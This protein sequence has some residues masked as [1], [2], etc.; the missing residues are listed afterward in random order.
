MKKPTRSPIV[1]VLGHVDHG[2][3]T[4]LDAIRATSVAA[5]EAGGITQGIG[6]SVVT[7]KG[8]QIT[9]ID[10]PGHAAFSNMRS[11]GS[12]VADIAILVVDASSGVKPQTIEA[13]QLIKSAKIPFI[14]VI[15]KIDLPSA[16][17]E[18]VKGQLTKEGILF[19]GR[20]G[21][22][23]I[24]P[25]SAKESKGLSELLETISLVAEV[26]EVKGNPDSPLEAVVIESGKDKRG[27]VASIVVRAGKIKIGDKIYAEGISGKVRALFNDKLE[28]VKEIGPGE[29]A[30][31]LGF[32]DV[33]PVGANVTF[34]VIP[35]DFKPQSQ[36]PAEVAQGEI[37]I[38]I[39]AKDLG[40]LEAL[41]GS[42]PKEFKVIVKGVGDIYESDVL[43]AKAN[44][45]RIFAFASGVSSSVEKLAETEGVSIEK[46][47]IIYELIERLENL[48][49]KGEVEILGKAEIITSFPYNSKKVAGCKV[50]SGRI[51]LKDNLILMRDDK[52]VERVK[53]SSMKKEKQEINEAKAGEEF[54]VLFEPQLD[55]VKGDVLVSVAK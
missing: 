11:R 47:E 10:T 22:T 41:E 54:G 7:T 21:D 18:E 9:F 34:G 4:L 13:I 53:I 14:V 3:T 15:T 12:K 17:I 42:I 44:G 48:F 29:P 49:K 33:P 55:F 1:C 36:K 46:F 6:A 31:V 20:G 32:E 24:V 16:N 40:S 50:I 23:P 2:K 28:S 30:Q 39:K 45:A 27:T 52:E 35:Q 8:K 26:N 51:A 43:S 5:K 37:P 25:V 38:L 19:E